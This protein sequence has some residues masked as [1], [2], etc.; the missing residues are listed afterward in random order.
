MN[1]DATELC[2][3]RDDDCDLLVDTDDPSLLGGT[4]WYTDHDFD[5]YGDALTGTLECEQPEGTV[6]N[7]LDCNDDEIQQHPGQPETCDNVDNDCDAL[8][9]DDDPDVQSDLVFYADADGD[10]FGDPAAI[11]SSCGDVPT[12]YVDNADDCDD[13]TKAVGTAVEYYND[14]D[15]D[16]H[17]AGPTHATC[18]PDADDTLVGDDCRPH[19]S[20][21]YPGAIE[22]CDGNDNNCDALVDED[23]PLVVLH[24]L[25][26][27][28]TT[29]TATATPAPRRPVAS[30]ATGYVD[31]GGDCDDGEA[32]VNP[33]ATEF[34]DSIDNDCTG[35]RRRCGRVQRLVRGRRRRRVRRRP[36]RR[37]RLRPAEAATCASAGDCDDTSDERESG[38]A[39]DLRERD[40]RRLRRGDRQLPDRPRGRRSHGAT[41]LPPRPAPGLV[42]QSATS[43]RTAPPI[44]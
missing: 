6:D 25:V 10:T 28:R 14:I 23:D 39:R 3:D 21:S 29:A 40:G 36:G 15:G 33:G 31:L 27:G 34:C 22:V 5:G 8:L 17:G 41:E 18:T 19:D 7:A 13:T 4:V 43:T 20:D 37:E 16:G 30:G 1:P 38:R 35:A 11:R 2:N 26:R 12:G 9:D 44:W 42:S 32:T 24:D